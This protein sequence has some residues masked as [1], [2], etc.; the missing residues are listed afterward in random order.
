MIR[1][2]AN[3][4]YRVHTRK[5]DPRTGSR[6]NVGTFAS[7]SEAERHERAAP[8]FKRRCRCTVIDRDVREHVRKLLAWEDAHVGF[9]KAVD[10]IP[11]EL[12]GRR[13]DGAPYSAWELLEHLRRTQRDILDFC[14]SPQYEE[15][16]WP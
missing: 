12:R 1:K 9:E 10:G 6:K 14:V 8:L 13:P 4:K 15:Q 16:S 2:L 11:P 5:K 3:G 7:R